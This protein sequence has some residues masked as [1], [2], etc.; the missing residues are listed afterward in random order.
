[1]R[2]L[3]EAYPHDDEA[4]VFSALSLLGTCHRGRD[5]RTYMQAAAIVEDVL[6]RNPQ[7][8]GALHYAIHCYDDPV[9]AP[10][11]LRAARVYGKVAPEAPHAL[12]MPS[13]IFFAMGMWPEAAESNER[14]FAASR[15]TQPMDAGGYHALWW[16]QYAYLQQGRYAD[17]RRTLQTMESMTGDSALA[18]F[19]LVQMHAM[20]SIET[21][22]PYT[23]ISQTGDV[24][25]PGRAADLFARGA[26]G[27]NRG[28]RRVADEALAAIRILGGATA[29]HGGHIYPGDARTVSVMEKELAA[30]LA[31]ADGKSKEGVALMKEAVAIEDGT[32]FEFGPPAPAK[33]S[34]ELLG[35]ML[36]L[37]EQP[38]LARVQFQLSLLRAPKR[39]L[40]LLGLARACVALGDKG[41]AREA[42]NDLQKI[43][44]GADGEIK[45][46]LA[47]SVEKL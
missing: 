36:L 10:L 3:Q 44:S 46:A 24:D 19:H 14:A 41:A 30:M 11:G 40:S 8:P 18:R 34:H 43:W 13:H 21:G 22:Q 25:L 27:L 28:N 1:M 42:Y 33:P 32:P 38:Q 47:E 2:R 17:A 31:M 7:H 37:L 9:H 29:G 26:D 12:H 4:A 15:R 45:R 35:E 39:A 16:L 6:L 23:V 20:Y 5:F